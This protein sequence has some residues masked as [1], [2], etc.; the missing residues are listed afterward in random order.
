V[1][2]VRRISLLFLAQIFFRILVFILTFVTDVKVKAMEAVQLPETHAVMQEPANCLA[3][4]VLNDQTVQSDSSSACA[5]GTRS[6]EKYILKLE[7]TSIVL[8]GRTSLLRSV[9]K[10]PPNHSQNELTLITGTLWVESVEAFTVHTEFGDVVGS[11]SFWV[12]HQTN[13]VIAV[14]S[15]TSLELRPRGSL[16]TLEVP[17]GM[18]NW[19]GKVASDAKAE[20]GVPQ[21]ISFEAHISRWARLYP[22]KKKAFALEVKAFH[23]QWVQAAQATADI[24]RELYERKIASMNAADAR[25][26][27]SLQAIKARDAELSAMFRRKALSGE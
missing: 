3:V 4:S 10:A 7:K 27:K 23:E 14:A 9:V 26:Q 15:Q 6:D 25:K 19:I 1:N 5:I 13:R 8:D 17:A 11:G 22:G 16:E 21:A 20:T 24:H 2:S 18:E 12:V